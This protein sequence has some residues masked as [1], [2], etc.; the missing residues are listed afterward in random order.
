VASTTE[1][2]GSCSICGAALSKRQMVR[3]LEACAFPG[4]KNLAAVTQI[5]VDVPGTP[6]WLDLDVKTNAT[7][8]HLDDF[9]RAIWL[10]CCD[11][12][13]AFEVD[14]VRYMV[15]R[16]DGFFRPPP[17]QRSMN[18]R[19]SA[20]LPPAGSVFSYEYDFGSTTQLRL[21]II[22]HREAPSRRENVRLLARN[23]APIWQCIECDETASA[24]CADCFLAGDAFLC[25]NHI[26]DH[27]CGDEAILP[28]VNSPRMGVCGY[29]G[30]D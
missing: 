21:K 23:D 30:G 29:T 3:H 25:D 13:S 17:S 2:M 15:A 28:V 5:R 6:F 4:G 14:K 1:S 24:V 20:S 26:D 9:L 10:E 19:V 16:E 22:A 27:E 11:H 12:L 8:H 18:T 7:L